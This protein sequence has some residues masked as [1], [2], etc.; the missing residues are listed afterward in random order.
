[1]SFSTWPVFPLTMLSVDSWINNVPLTFILS[2]LQA[3]GHMLN[4]MYDASPPLANFF[5]KKEKKI[6]IK[7]SL[8]TEKWFYNGVHDKMEIFL[9]LFI[10]LILR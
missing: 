10:F 6:L 5:F 9:F 8:W 4:E 7:I 2:K 3:L 1:V